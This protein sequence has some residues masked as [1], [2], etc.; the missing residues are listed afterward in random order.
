MVVQLYLFAFLA[1]TAASQVRSPR[2]PPPGS[3]CPTGWN[4][5]RND[6]DCSATGCCIL[7]NSILQSR[8]C[9][10]PTYLALFRSH[11]ECLLPAF[12]GT[13]PPRAP[14]PT[15]KIVRCPFILPVDEC[16][17]D[18]ECPL[19]L[20]GVRELCCPYDVVPGCNGG[21]RCTAPIPLPD[22]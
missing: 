9:V 11:G 22:S 13:C 3:V 5:C 8:C 4:S 10:H 14:P 21:K 1:L 20:R 6:S 7:L 17:R 19:G 2:G 18:D 16:T 12:K 15:T